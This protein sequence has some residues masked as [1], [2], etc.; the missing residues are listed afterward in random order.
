MGLVE[1]NGII[2]GGG[3]VEEEIKS[4]RRYVKLETQPRQCV[5]VNGKMKALDKKQIRTNKRDEMR[6][7]KTFF[8]PFTSS[9]FSCSRCS[10]KS[11]LA[12]RLWTVESGSRTWAGPRAARAA[13]AICPHPCLQ[14]RQ[15]PQQPQ[16]P[17]RQP[18]NDRHDST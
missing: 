7:D 5:C 11:K 1:L 8:F 14:A 4:S 3:D 10:W 12:D 15:Q 13:R 17:A 9:C 6:R 16:Q 18:S 2:D